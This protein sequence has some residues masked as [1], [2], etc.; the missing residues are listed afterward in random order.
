MQ[1]LVHV[2]LIIG[3]I[4]LG[5]LTNAQNAATPTP[6]PPPTEYV[7]RSGEALSSVAAR[8]GTTVR[9]IALL[10]NI[11]NVNLIYAG[12]RILIPAPDVPLEILAQTAQPPARHT[13]RQGDTLAAIASLYGTT[14]QDLIAL[15]EIPA[16]YTIYAG[17]TLL[18]RAV[19]TTDTET[20]DESES[21][22]ATPPPVP[23]EAPA[24]P[25]ATETIEVATSTPEA[26]AV[27]LPP[28]NAFGYGVMAF[29]PASASVEPF[30]QKIDLLGMQWVRL[31]VY[32]RD[33]EAVQGQ[34]DFTALDATIEALHAAGI[35]VL[36]TVS[37]SPA[38][39]RADQIE[40][41]PPDDYAPF[42]LFVGQLADRYEG[43]VQAFQIWSEPNLRREWYNS[44]HRL[45]A[46]A[47]VNLLR[48]AHVS[49][50]TANPTA[51]VISA[52][53]APTGFNDGINAIDDR[54]YLEEMYRR[55][56]IAVTD[57]VAAHA[58]G[59]A[60][61]PDATC[62]SP[63]LGVESHYDSRTFF[64]KD[65][66]DDY[67][68]IMQAYG[69]VRPLWVTE[70]GWGTVE[71]SDLP[72]PG[73]SYQFINY[74][75][76]NEQALYSVRAF[77]LGRSLGFVGPMFL[78]NLNGCVSDAS[79]VENCYYSLTGPDGIDRPAYAALQVMPKD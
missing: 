25:T 75:S 67:H 20:T 4:A 6:I 54:L 10:N 57:A 33:I 47:Y 55:G 31:N 38:W 41:G 79:R 40:D 8:F 61:P 58:G 77:E 51:L 19:P 71:G 29:V 76:L 68:I 42:G 17:E 15:N 45:S 43:K 59:W 52:G 9:A 78:D 60:N 56:V 37:T 69:D 50:K 39:A 44:N 46:E 32:W 13:I 21:A 53:L 16:P 2:I 73:E 3:A 24:E 22:S 14:V 1:K 30:A 64:F 74:N 49:I 70:F 11:T 7:L 35:R 12:Q 5:T 27:P 28:N 23:M 63:T 62:C 18:I 72:T 66:L 34:P 36:L 48:V 26:P 65:T